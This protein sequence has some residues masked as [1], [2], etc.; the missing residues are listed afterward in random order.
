FFAST[1]FTQSTEDEATVH[2]TDVRIGS[3]YSFHTLPLELAI[4]YRYYHKQEIGTIDTLSKRSIR[5]DANSALSKTMKFSLR[6]EFTNYA[7]DN[8]NYL[9]SVKWRYIPV[10][11]LLITSG[12]L[13]FKTDS[14]A[15]R[16]YSN[17]SDLPGLSSFISLYGTG[18]RYYIGSTYSGICGISLS[19]RIGE[20][21]FSYQSG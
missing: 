16:F 9:A 21:R 13:F 15:S 2:Y 10:N 7:N 19:A 18:F 20:S 8:L 14:Y 3:I 11:G 17:E 1:Q 5:L 6:T 12:V 4:S